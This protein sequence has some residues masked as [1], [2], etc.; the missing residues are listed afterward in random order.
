MRYFQATGNVELVARKGYSDTS[1]I[2]GTLKDLFQGGLNLYGEKARAEGR[3]E[4][5]RE[6]AHAAQ[7]RGGGMPGWV[8]PC[9]GPTI[10]TMP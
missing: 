5:Y 7:P 8:M 2:G 3:A 10:C 1:G 4:A 6:Q 9:S